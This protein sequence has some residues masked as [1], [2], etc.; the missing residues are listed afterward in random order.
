LKKNLPKVLKGMKNE[1]HFQINLDFLQHRLQIMTSEKKEQVFDLNSLSV[2]SCYNNILKTLK[3]L[4]IEAKINPMPN[5]IIDAIPFHLDKEHSTY[6]PQHAADLHK[7]LLKANDIFTQFRSEF[8]GKCSPVHFFWGSFDLA[9]SRF[10]GQEAPLH[11]G[12]IPNLPDRVV[13]EAYSHEVSSC[14]FWPG[15]EAVPFAAF[16]SYIYPEPENFMSSSI[17]PETAYYHKELREFLLPYE[18]VQRAENPSKALLDFLHSSYE[19]AANLS[20]WNRN[21]LEK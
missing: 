16:Y 20:H 15:N 7:A 11:P 6:N 18:E 21:K 9:V 3:E 10:S 1:K 8:I 19:A 2:A 14:G 17:K 4:G 5:E 12:G 13:Q